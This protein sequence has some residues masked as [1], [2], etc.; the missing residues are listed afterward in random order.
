MSIAVLVSGG[1]D[2]SVALHRLVAEGH[3]D[4][5]A[6]YLKIWLED[7]LAFL[8]ECPWEEDLA[9]VRAVCDQVNV[10]LEVVPL[11][12]EYW[13]RVVSHAIRELKA[14][15]T[16]SPDI[17]CNQQIKFGAFVEHLA[18]HF[19]HIAT[20]HYAI[21]TH[22]EGKESRLYKGNDPVKDQTYFLSYL[23]PEQ[24][25]RCLFPVGSMPK[26]EVR[27]LAA[28][29]A[30]PNRDRPDSQGICFLG[31]IKYD[32]FVNYHLG[33]REGAIVELETGKKLGT[34][35]GYWFH[36]I[37]QRKG[38]G[39]SG[40]P[41]YVV[42]KDIN[43]NVVYVSRTEPGQR[44]TDQRREFQVAALNWLGREA[45]GRLASGRL[46]VK[47]RHGAKTIPCTV[48]LNADGSAAQVHLEEADTG[49]AP[50][51]FTV[52][53]D[54]QWCLGSGIITEHHLISVP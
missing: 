1:V 27:E 39:L 42:N 45:Y 16:P 47:V 20:G 11:Q 18:P 32:T 23:S 2:S 14:G 31:K 7:E 49:I 51:Q 8:G 41:W 36:T 9:F 43:D 44:F 12:K 25:S 33:D 28:Q 22:E 26:R 13:D 5:T 19:S 35:R 34:H 29:Y 10:P 54:N 4:I 40:G 30:L 46:S 50:G 24:L 21:V 17:L 38:L 3:R 15:R 48:T 52:F 6:F 37:G 53:Y